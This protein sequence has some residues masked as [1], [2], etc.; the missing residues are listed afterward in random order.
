[1]KNTSS[2]KYKTKQTRKKEGKTPTLGFNDSAF[3][4]GRMTKQHPHQ[5]WGVLLARWTDLWRWRKGSLSSWRFFWGSLRESPKKSM[6]GS[7]NVSHNTGLERQA[8]QVVLLRGR[9]CTVWPMEWESNLS[10]CGAAEHTLHCGMDE[11]LEVTLQTVTPTAFH[12]W[13]E[14]VD[15]LSSLPSGAFMCLQTGN[16]FRVWD[17]KQVAHRLE[18]H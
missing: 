15:S 18:A 5:R 10:V 11:K 12:K 3:W 14:H 4:V 13:H 6:P 1:M 16:K 9:L 8:A 17:W 2:E 7:G